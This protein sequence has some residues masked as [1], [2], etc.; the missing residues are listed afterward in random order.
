MFVHSSWKAREELV[1]LSGFKYNGGH[2][3]FRVFTSLKRGISLV[4][5]RLEVSKLKKR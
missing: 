1:F 3:S 5:Q 4:F 2:R